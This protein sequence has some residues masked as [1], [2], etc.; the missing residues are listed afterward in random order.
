MANLA[1][2]KLAGT[3]HLVRPGDKFEV[4]RLENEVEMAFNPEVL[5]STKGDDLMFNE[6]NVEIKVL[7][8][9][10]G[11]KIFV[12]KF[13][14]KSRYLRRT[15]HK[16]HLS[17][18]EVISVNGEKKEKT[19]TKEAKIEE[20]APVV[21]EKQKAVKKTASTTTK[22]PAVKKAAPVKKAVKK[23]VK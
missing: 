23:E 16:Q 5:L 6:G 8:Q 20:A 17:L 18:V 11:E 22:K 2:I 10:R 4:N 14:A 21:E 9:T 19:T 15:G 12:I 1:V 3:Q 13:K 7:G